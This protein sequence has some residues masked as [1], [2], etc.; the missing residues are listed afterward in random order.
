VL[1]ESE[2]VQQTQGLTQKIDCSFTQGG[3]CLL[4]LEQAVCPIGRKLNNPET[5]SGQEVDL[6]D[7]FY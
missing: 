7:S 1:H 6:I 4:C 5:G 3:V 2:T